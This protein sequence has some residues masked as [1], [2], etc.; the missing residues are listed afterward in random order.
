MALFG[1]FVVV[2]FTLMLTAWPFPPR[3]FA[4]MAASYLLKLAACHLGGRSA[5]RHEVAVPA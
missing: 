4:F 3:L 1:L 2:D 5:A